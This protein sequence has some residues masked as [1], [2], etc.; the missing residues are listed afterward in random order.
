VGL[1]QKQFHILN[2]PVSK[3]EYFETLQSIQSGNQSVIEHI[4]NGVA[5]LLKKIP[6]KS[7]HGDHNENCSGDYI[8][9]SKNCRE[10]YDV[11][12]AWDCAYCT[13]F[14]AGKDC[15]DVYSWGDQE[16]CYEVCS[17]GD[18][19]YGCA[20]TVKSFG[21]KECFYTD[22]CM[23]SKNCFACVGLKNAQYCILNK[24]YTKSEYEALIPQIINLM[25]SYGEWGELFP[26]K[27]SPWGY[28]ES[29]AIQYHPLSK[30]EALAQNFSWN[31]YAPPIPQATT[32]S[33]NVLLRPIEEIKDDLLKSAIACEETGRAFKIIPQELDF[34]ISN[35]LPIPKKH[36]DVRHQNRLR[37]RNP[38]KLFN[39]FCEKCGENIQST[40]EPTRPE[41]VYCEPCY[42]G[43]IY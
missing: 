7:F 38:R 19:H 25:Q 20:F 2:S 21:C 39:R 22:L 1:R 43:V 13:W 24:Q 23:Y 35:K 31:D 41:V 4:K 37:Q 6:H 15:M 14:V 30:E 27:N 8:W 18:K 17:G 16:L 9:S 34:Y 10:C 40:Y 36:H 3:E 32:I 26:S 33:P 11:A 5:S 29:V 42:L 12:N 28:N